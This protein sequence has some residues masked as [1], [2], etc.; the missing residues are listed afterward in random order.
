MCLTTPRRCQDVASM[1]DYA[2]LPT[3]QR[4]HIMIHIQ[5]NGRNDAHGPTEQIAPK[6]MYIGLLATKI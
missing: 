4:P 1:P 2:T 3:I 6:I 5:T